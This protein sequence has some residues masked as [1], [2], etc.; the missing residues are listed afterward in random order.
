MFKMKNKLTKII[1]I[2]LA[3][4]MLFCF[5]S[6]SDESTSVSS[7]A[8][9]SEVIKTDINVA[10]LKGPTA[11]GMLSLMDKNEAKDAAN[12]YKFQTFTAP[13]DVV[14]KIVNKSIDIAAVPTNVAATLYKKTEGNVS[15]LAVNT[16]GVLSIVTNGVE[17][18]SVSD[19]RGKTI[20]ATGQ[21]ATNEYALNYILEQNGLKVGTDVKVEYL[22]EHA[23]L[24]TKVIAN[25]AEIALLP[26][27]FVTNVCLKND[28][29]KVALDL[30]KEWEKI[31]GNESKLTM[32]CIVVRNDFLKDNAAAVEKFLTEYA[33]STEFANK[34]IDK[35]AALSEKF[36]ILPAAV[37]KKALPSCNIV[38]IAGSE[39]KASV[40]KYLD[41]L[42]KANPVSVGGSLPGDGFYYEK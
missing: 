42:F 22:S 1:S 8:T 14:P 3:V 39:M 41:V 26:Q 27:P 11:L 9:Q 36:D 37:V 25:Q 38:Y 18:S 40:S 23:E 30:T 15:I 12:N 31:P 34:E 19:L 35:T 10:I 13:T 17:I 24:A 7:T 16:L 28:K 21:G 32:G 33:A 29:V 5:A 4:S 20:Y 6:C 2:L